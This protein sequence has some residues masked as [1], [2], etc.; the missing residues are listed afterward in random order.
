MR[1]ILKIKTRA[2]FR[3]ALLYKL[4][5]G[6]HSIFF[7]Q[8]AFRKRML[9]TADQLILFMSLTGEQHDISPARFTH[10]KCDRILAQRKDLT[11]NVSDKRRA[12]LSTDLQRILKIRVIRRQYRKIARFAER[13]A[14]LGAPPLGAAADRSQ[15]ADQTRGRYAR[16]VASA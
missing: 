1:L 12:D 2:V 9:S 5:R 13:Y 6:L 16:S 11:R 15:N 4:S 3:N 14:K 7:N 8:L 10:G